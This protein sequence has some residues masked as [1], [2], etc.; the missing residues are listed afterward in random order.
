VPECQ[1]IEKGGSDQYDAERLNSLI[2][3]QSEKC[4]T[5]RVNVCNQIKSNK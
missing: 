3:S 4:G 1:K 5:E 2:L